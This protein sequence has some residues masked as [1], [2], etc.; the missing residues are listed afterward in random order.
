MSADDDSPHHSYEV[1][2]THNAVLSNY[3][4]FKAYMVLLQH[5][6]YE[7]AWDVLWHVGQAFREARR[8][9]P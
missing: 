2:M 6:T 4:D 7:S 3:M 5:N 8:I 9:N 1:D